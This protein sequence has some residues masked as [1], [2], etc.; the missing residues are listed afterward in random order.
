MNEQVRGV[1]PLSLAWK[2]KVIP[3]Y[4]TCKIYIRGAENR[5]QAKRSQSVYTTIIRRPVIFEDYITF[6]AKIKE[7]LIILFVDR[8]YY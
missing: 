3:I 5:T 6:S 7:L 2:A 1:E 8:C 4:D